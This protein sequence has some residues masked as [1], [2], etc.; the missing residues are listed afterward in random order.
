MTSG[1]ARTKQHLAATG[2]ILY[3]ALTD[4]ADPLV[5]KTGRQFPGGRVTLRRLCPVCD[6][7]KLA[8]KMVADPQRFG[9]AVMAVFK[10]LPQRAQREN[11][12]LYPPAGQVLVRPRIGAARVR[13]SAVDNPYRPPCHWRVASANTRQSA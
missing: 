4:S 8:G 6:A 2:Q 9:A 3:L 12:E 5:G 13:R 10:A 7:Q 11:R 1:N